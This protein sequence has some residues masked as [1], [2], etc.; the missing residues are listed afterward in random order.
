MMRFHFLIPLALLRECFFNNPRSISRRYVSHRLHCQKS[1]SLLANLR[2]KGVF[3]YRWLG[4]VLLPGR[5]KHRLNTP[6]TIRVTD[7]LD[8]R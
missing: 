3:L 4:T 5:R 8:L 7:P 6:A 2:G 1:F